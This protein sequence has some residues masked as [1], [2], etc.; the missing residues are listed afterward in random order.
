MT[1]KSQ[2]LTLSMREQIS[3]T[4]LFLTIFSLLVILSIIG[5]LTYQILTQDYNQ[6]KLY[7]FSKYKEYI[8]NSLYF[9]N[10]YL[11]QYE[12][13]I[14]RIQ[15]EIWEFH[16]I[17]DIYDNKNFPKNLAKEIKNILDYDPNKNKENDVNNNLFFLCY[18][19]EELIKMN[20]DI[21]ERPIE[22]I[23]NLINRT[24]YFYFGFIYES[25]SSLIITHNID[26]AFHVPGYEMP[27]INPPLFVNIDEYYMYSFNA[28]Q[29][30][31]S[32]NEAFGNISNINNKELGNYYKKK[33]NDTLMRINNIFLKF[34]NNELFLI[35]Y[36]FGKVYKEIVTS[37]EFLSLDEKDNKKINEF[38]NAI[39]GHFTSINYG[40][41]KFSIFTHVNN[42]SFYCETSIIDNY[43]Y[44]INNK[45]S[46]Y[47]NISFIPLYYENDTI[48]SPE[49]YFIL[50]N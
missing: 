36:S 2:F 39:C 1:V 45:L 35:D 26:T 4:I 43:L 25:F 10:F 17:E 5:S 24:I 30:L 49:L 19:P 48:I 40:N 11:L 50:D 46:H 12:E 13:I 32:I 42:E 47:L 33:Y 28:S 15:K 3:L 29:I 21:N 14:K 20:I 44:Y 38:L 9:Q 27:I 8:E 22:D 41:S 18:Y 7:F 37:Q 23:Y 16:Q 34:S 6:K 31:A